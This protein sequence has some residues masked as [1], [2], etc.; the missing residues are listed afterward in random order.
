MALT[1]ALRGTSLDAWYSNNGKTAAPFGNVVNDPALVVNTN[2]GVFGSSVIDMVPTSVTKG[3]I[4]PGITNV[5]GLTNNGQFSVI[6]RIVPTVS[7]SP[8]VGYG[9]IEVAC[10]R[11]PY[12]FAYRCGI[13]SL[14]KAYVQLSDLA[15]NL[16]T[17][18]GTTV[19]NVTINVPVEF[20]FTFDGTATAG[21]IL[22][23]KDGAALESLT[24]TNTCAGRISR[25]MS[26]LI[27]GSIT[28]GPTTTK[29]NLNELL[30]WDTKETYTYTARTDFWSVSTFDGLSN[31]DPGI[32]TVLSGQ[33]YYMAGI[34]K[35]GTLDIADKVW[36]AL[37]ASY[38]TA[39][40]FGN[41]M[42]RLLTVA[43]F[44][45]LK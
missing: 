18:T 11:N 13:S 45:G 38:T 12:G 35:T 6:C 23:S 1:F 21:A 2:T 44:L 32:A 37:T 31:T 33:T 16:T 30:V 14:G 22:I 19:N 5:C 9:C 3:L 36:N 27:T 8:F 10:S 4:F 24:S 39:S 28:A 15:G 40:T 34:L 26:N 17:Y 43:K 20:M 7:A 25:A 41:L 29:A 42:S